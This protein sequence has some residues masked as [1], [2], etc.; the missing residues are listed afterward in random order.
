MRLLYAIDLRAKE[1]WRMD[2]VGR[3]ASSLGGTVDLVFVDPFGSYEPYVLNA[4]LAEHLKEG[5]ER[6]RARDRESLQEAMDELPETT[7][8]AVHVLAGD[9]APTVVDLAK[10]F[11]VLVVSTRG[12]KGAARLWLGS[13]AERIVRSHHGDTL[14]LNA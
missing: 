7:R 1:L 12:R 9:P 4:D 5:L 8:G 6:A 3:W 10:D 14:V 11:D 13:I 2:E